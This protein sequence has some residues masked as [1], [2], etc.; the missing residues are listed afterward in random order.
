[1]DDSTQQAKIYKVQML[2]LKYVVSPL[3]KKKHPD[4]N[5]TSTSTEKFRREAFFEAVDQLLTSTDSRIAAYEFSFRHHL[6]FCRTETYFGFGGR[7]IA[8]GER[9]EILSCIPQ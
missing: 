8:E 3:I 1:M 9:Q 5:L 4:A 6:G 2:F 7:K